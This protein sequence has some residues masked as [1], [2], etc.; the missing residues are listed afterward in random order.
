MYNV[1][2]KKF[3]VTVDKINNGKVTIDG[4]EFLHLSKVLRTKLKEKVAILCGD[5]FVYFA[6]VIEIQKHFAVLEIISREV[7]EANP[8]CKITLF[9]GL[10][11]GEK[12]DVITQKLNE[13]GAYQIIPFE[14]SFT[15]AKNNSLKKERLEK[16]SIE[17]C[18]QCGRSVPLKIGETIKL[19][20]IHNY[21]SKFDLVIFLNEKAD[22]EQTINKIQKEILKSENIA[23]IVG[24]E[25]GF[26]QE[27]I[28]F[29]TKLNVKNIS[30]GKRILRTETASISLV[31]FISLLKNN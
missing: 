14:S 25:G 26:S 18:K 11:K 2:M 6:E 29:I 3:Y 5:E 1:I 7:C 28:D 16:I 13:L 10:A 23:L 9:Q 30:L 8:K 27:E 22:T 31:G 24:S 20:D 17:A 19:K 4:D 15:I 21:L 12:L